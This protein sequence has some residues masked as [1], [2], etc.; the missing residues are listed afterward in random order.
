MIIIII[1]VHIGDRFLQVKRPN[2]QCRSTEGR[3]DPKKYASVPSGPT[4]SKKKMHKIQ[5]HKHK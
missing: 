2:Q 4:C 3:Q 5:T 1:L